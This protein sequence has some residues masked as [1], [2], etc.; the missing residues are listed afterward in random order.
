VAGPAAARR[1]V[2][3]GGRAFFGSGIGVTLADG[4]EN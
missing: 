1:P 3:V 2:Q 4:I